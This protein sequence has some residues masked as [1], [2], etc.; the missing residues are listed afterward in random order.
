[1]ANPNPQRGKTRTRQHVIADLDVNYVE[2]QILLAAF[3]VERVT[4]DYGLDMSM[5]TFDQ[6]GVVESGS[7]ELQV[8]ATERFAPHANGETV[9][10]RVEVE[11]LK[12]WLFEWVPIV[13]VLYEASG[14]R[15]CWIDI[16]DYAQEHEI[17]ENIGGITATL[18]IPLS[19]TFDS[20]AIAAMRERKNR[21]NPHKK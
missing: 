10:L 17:D 16:Q 15:A 19:N 21:M 12:S 8:K 13:L 14:D 20:P 4:R 9:P 7:V 6:H 2:R 5:T 3:T 18:R 1:V 11:D